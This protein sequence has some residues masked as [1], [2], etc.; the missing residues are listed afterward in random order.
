[1]NAVSW[2]DEIRSAEGAHRAVVV[3]VVIVKRRLGLG[4]G[5]P[6][7]DGGLSMPSLLRKQNGLRAKPHTK[8]SELNA[9][10]L[11]E[12]DYKSETGVA[13]DPR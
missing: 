12:Q 3:S 6:I 2:A 8:N 5:K 13:P 4:V 1:M 10:R 11:I 9:S 7:D